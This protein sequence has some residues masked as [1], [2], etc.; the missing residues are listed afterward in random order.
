MIPSKD[1]RIILAAARLFRS[2][3]KARIEKPKTQKTNIYPQ[4]NIFHCSWIWSIL[5][6][7]VISFNYSSKDTTDKPLR[8]SNYIFQKLLNVSCNSITYYNLF[9]FESNCSFFNAWIKYALTKIIYQNQKKKTCFRAHLIFLHFGNLFLVENLSWLFA[10]FLIVGKQ[11]DTILHKSFWDVWIWW[12]FTC[13]VRHKT[14]LNWTISS[15]SYFYLLLLSWL[16]W[17]VSTILHNL[18][19]HLHSVYFVSS[20]EHPAN[21]GLQAKKNH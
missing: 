19:I 15:T 18:I 1:T 3:W 20:L 7:Q 4:P 16:S 17:A 13:T 14:F 10:T 21:E 12:L 11:R 6:V 9:G 2:F 5:K 8:I